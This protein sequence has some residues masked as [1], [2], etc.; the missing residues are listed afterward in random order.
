MPLL[1]EIRI[2]Y[3]KFCFKD[4]NAR[5]N[6]HYYNTIELCNDAYNKHLHTIAQS[7]NYSI[8]VLQKKITQ[9]QLHIKVVNIDN[10]I[11]LNTDLYYY[12][13]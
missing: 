7:L 3:K 9:Y 8:N 1:G 12:S 6:N 10:K 4:I 5:D 11:P 2:R 13:K